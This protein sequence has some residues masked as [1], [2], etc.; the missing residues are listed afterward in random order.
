M[1]RTAVIAGSTGLVGG[2]CLQLLNSAPEYERVHPLVRG[3]GGLNLDFDAA[4]DVHCAIGTTIQKAGSQE[5]FRQVDLEI[6]VTLARRALEAGARRYLV[7]SSVGADPDSSNFYLK[8]KG[9]MER[10]LAS[11]AFEAVHIFRP[12]FLMGNRKES[13]PGEKVGIVMARSLAPLLIGGL[14]KYRPVQ[15]QAV[16]SAMVRAALS[17]SRGVHIHVFTFET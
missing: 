10:E 9:E 11:L 7:V 2:H 5:A 4:D 3:P 15:A 1:A 6:P 13:R 17:P 12:S 16:A 14:R 8:T